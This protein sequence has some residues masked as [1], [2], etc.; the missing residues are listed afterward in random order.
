[1]NDLLLLLYI[2]LGIKQVFVFLMQ[3]ENYLWLSLLSVKNMFF[4]AVMKRKNT[5]CSFTKRKFQK[6][7]VIGWYFYV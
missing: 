5:K 7:Y 1:M 2:S 4:H 3:T 6:N